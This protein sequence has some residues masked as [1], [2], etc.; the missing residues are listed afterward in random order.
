MQTQEKENRE[1]KKFTIHL[2]TN[3]E[4]G[5][6]GKMLIEE[7]KDKFVDVDNLK[8]G[9]QSD[10]EKQIK[11]MKKYP[12]LNDLTE[13]ILSSNNHIESIFTDFKKNQEYFTIMF[14]GCVN[15]GKSSMICDISNTTPNTL[16]E[17]IVYQSGFTDELDKFTIGVNVATLNLYELLF[18]DSNLRIVDVPGIGGL[19]HDNSLIL[20]FADM[21]DCIVFMIDANTEAKMSEVKFLEEIFDKIS[22]DKKDKV[23]IYDSEKTVIFVLNK[24]SSVCPP[25]DIP[26]DMSEEIFLNKKVKMLEGDN[27][28]MGFNS[29]FSENNQPIMVKTNTAQ[30]LNGA[31]VNKKKVQIDELVTAI[32]QILKTKGKNIRLNRP[33]NVLIKEF[34]NMRAELLQMKNDKVIRNSLA[35]LKEAGFNIK[36]IETNVKESTSTN[37]ELVKHTVYTE[38]EYAI[39]NAIDQWKPEV[40]WG[41]K[42]GMM[43]PNWVASNFDLETGSN[44]VKQD[45][46]ERWQKEMVDLFV[47]NFDNNKIKKIAEEQFKKISEILINSFENEIKKVDPS[48][49]EKVNKV[50]KIKDLDTGSDLNLPN[51]MGNVVENVQNEILGDLLTVVIAE[52]L[53]L[54]LTKFMF[55]ITGPGALLIL[56][57]RRLWNWATGDSK[58]REAK[59]KEDLNREIYNGATEASDN[60]KT[61]IEEIISANV[62]KLYQSYASII[63]ASLNEYLAPLE[64]VD[65]TIVVIE[66]RRAELSEINFDN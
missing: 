60:V 50:S 37:I 65:E 18:D 12:I 61:K 52:T 16:N 57:V 5:S 1:I 51:M 23:E 43:V 27:S 13:A 11:E 62:S 8:R 55:F 53:V 49:T 35:A 22:S 47:K 21:A 46:K 10:L 42:F 45:L 41:D 66:K 24:W 20:P 34:S 38:V 29:L 54:V 2:N 39:R 15:A 30:Y 28:R 7:I 59:M 48:L 14:F 56:G 64:L 17:Q 4:L 40:G 31:P 25:D 26:L 9:F 6:F 3:T 44:H 33:K 19:T 58:K 63:D 36:N 32:N